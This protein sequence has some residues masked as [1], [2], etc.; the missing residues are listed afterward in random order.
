[1]EKALKAAE[2]VQKKYSEYQKF[3]SQEVNRLH[4]KIKELTNDNLSKQSETE[5]ISK[6]VKSNF[7]DKNYSN[8]LKLVI[9]EI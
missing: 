3:Y 7:Y 5:R 8:N 4:A 2:N 6:E 9:F 1:M